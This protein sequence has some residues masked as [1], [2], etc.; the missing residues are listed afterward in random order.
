[1]LDSH[2]LNAFICFSRAVSLIKTILNYCYWQFD[3]ILFCSRNIH[4]N[5][6]AEAEPEN[7]SGI[8]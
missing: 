5:A 7:M 1:M 6:L 3:L 8:F 4:M 2:I